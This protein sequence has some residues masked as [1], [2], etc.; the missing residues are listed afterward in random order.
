MG[1]YIPYHGYS[2][3]KVKLKTGDTS[4]RTLGSIWIKEYIFTDHDDE[5]I[6]GCD[7]GTILSHN[8]K[9]EWAQLSSYNFF[10]FKDFLQ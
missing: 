9:H 2:F 4:Q 7:Q 6:S 5:V 1:C 10:S 8:I 3:S